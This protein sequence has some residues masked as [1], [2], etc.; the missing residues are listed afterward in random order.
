MTKAIQKALHAARVY[1]G[2]TACNI[3]TAQRFY[4][5]YRNACSAVAKQT[6]MDIADVMSQIGAQA[7]RLGAITPTPGKDF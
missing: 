1:A 7:N 2:S 5:R 4:D 3:K 6:G